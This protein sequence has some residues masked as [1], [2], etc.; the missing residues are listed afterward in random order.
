MAG[1][2]WLIAALRLQSGNSLKLSRDSGPIA[3]GSKFNP[4]D[5]GKTHLRKCGF[6]NIC[7]TAESAGASSYTH[8][9][10][11]VLPAPFQSHM[12]LIMC[13]RNCFEQ[14]QSK[15]RICRSVHLHTFKLINQRDAAINYRFIACRLS[16]AQHDFHLITVHVVTF[17]LLKTNS[18]TFQFMSSLMSSRPDNTQTGTPDTHTNGGHMATKK[19]KTKDEAGGS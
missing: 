18:C 12:Y 19:K 14:T 13:I 9:L 4:D 1:R 10:W 2:I 5:G 3:A 11:F 16:T 17:T 7:I 6:W 8:V 15:F